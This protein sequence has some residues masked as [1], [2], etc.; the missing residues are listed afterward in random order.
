MMRQQ[1]TQA[2]AAQAW[3]FRPCISVLALGLLLVGLVL[4]SVRANERVIREALPKAFAGMPKIDE[5][6]PSPLPGLWAVRIGGQIL[7]TNA[8]ATLLVEGQMVD[9]RTKANL[10]KQA[11]DKALA[12]DFDTLPLRDALVT[13]KDG[14]GAQRI[15][16]FAD[17]TCG[18]CKR[19]EPALHDLKDVTVYTF[20]VAMLGP[21][22]T[23]M[24]Q[25]VLCDKAPA[26]AWNAWMLKGERPPDP[27]PGCDSS[28]LERNKALAARLGVSG[29]PTTL[30][31]DRSRLT[32]A[33]P[34]EALREAVAK[35]G[36]A[37]PMASKST[38]Q[39]SAAMAGTAKP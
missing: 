3:S 16:V 21:Q 10:T 11:L 7:Y 14:T 27:A 12:V 39:T 32:G 38:P 5:V 2:P 31:T 24:S 1:L 30:L 9:T 26:Q 37:K 36:S 22:A 19:F 17:P 25:R 23:D 33:V 34:A 13:H 20:V 8:D 29:T 28:V 15:A 6:S 4:Q 35:A 18:F